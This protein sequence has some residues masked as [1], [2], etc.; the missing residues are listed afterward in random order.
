[1]SRYSL[2][3]R[4]LI[5][6]TDEEHPDFKS[7]STALNQVM[8]ISDY[9]NEAKRKSERAARALELTDLITGKPVERINF[10]AS[11]RYYLREEAAEF[12]TEEIQ[13]DSVFLFLFSDVLIISNRKKQLMSETFVAKYIIWLADIE[14]VENSIGKYF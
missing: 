9:L 11:H 8:E 10:L 6:Y 12:F 7:L 4:D 5:N 2:L 13:K 1:M 3:L 14:L